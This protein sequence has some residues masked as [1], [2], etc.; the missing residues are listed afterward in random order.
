M[1]S[2]ILPIIFILWV[3]CFPFSVL[4]ATG[5]IF[6]VPSLGKVHY[7]LWLSCVRL[8]YFSLRPEKIMSFVFSLTRSNSYFF[9][10]SLFLSYIFYLFKA[11]GRSLFSVSFVLTFSRKLG[12][13]LVLSNSESISLLVQPLP[14]ALSFASSS[15]L[16]F[17]LSSAQFSVKCFDLSPPPSI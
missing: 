9:L 3:C 5:I 2:F 4:F 8:I 1:S 6:S 17:P 13:N 15:A 16:P 12:W 10:P 7:S 14:F 11:N